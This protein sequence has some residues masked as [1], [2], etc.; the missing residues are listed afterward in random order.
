MAMCK[1]S[2][3][4]FTGMMF[5]WTSGLRVL[6]LAVSNPNNCIALTALKR[7]DETALKLNFA[8][9]AI[10]KRLF[11]LRTLTYEST[12]QTPAMRQKP[13]KPSRL[14]SPPSGESF[15]RRKP[16]KAQDC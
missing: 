1:A 11:P 14:E 5:V 16:P 15:L 8:L 9:L 6:R 3:A 12:A 4:A 13:H 7:C 10:R 2:S